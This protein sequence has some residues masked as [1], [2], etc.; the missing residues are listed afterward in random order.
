M[1]VGNLLSGTDRKTRCA[2]VH[3]SS[4]TVLGLGT[5]YEF[6]ESC[7]GRV[8]LYEP[9]GTMLANRSFDGATTKEEFMKRVFCAIARTSSRRSGV[10][11][12]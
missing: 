5:E 8:G 10:S 2:P 7:V 3:L 6:S 9:R 4:T 12:H 11:G 1:A